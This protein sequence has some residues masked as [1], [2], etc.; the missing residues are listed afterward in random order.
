MAKAKGKFSKKTSGKI[1]TQQDFK[2][3]KKEFKKHLQ[4]GGKSTSIMLKNLPFSV[5][6]GDI[7]QHFKKFGVICNVNLP[8]KKG[9]KLTG[10]GFV[11]FN[12]VDAAESAMKQCS[13]EDFMGRKLRVEWAMPL[14]EVK[15]DMKKEKDNSARKGKSNN[16]RRNVN[17]ED[18]ED[19]NMA[20]D[21]D[22]NMA[23]EIEDE[24]KH[25]LNTNKPA[26]EEINSLSPIDNTPK[27]N[28]HIAKKGKIIVR[29]LS[30]KTTEEKL[31]DYFKEFGA[32]S[33]VKLLKKDDGKLVGCGFV[34]FEKKLS[35]QN[36]IQERNAK[37]FLGRPIVCDWAIPKDQYLKHMASEMNN[38]E[39]K[40]AL[41]DIKIKKEPC[42]DESDNEAH[43]KMDTE[44]DSDEKDQEWE[45]EEEEDDDDD[46]DDDDDMEEDEVDD[47][48]DDSENDEY[49]TNKRGIK[50]IKV[51]HEKESK[52]P[53][54]ISNDVTE[55]C[56]I[57]IKNIPFSASNDD[58]KKCMKQFGPLEYA[59]ICMDKLTEHSKGTGFVKFKKKEDAE[60]CLKTAEPI[61]INDQTIEVLSAIPRD[62]ITSMADKKKEKVVKDKR[63]LYLIKEGVIL[64]GSAAAKDVSVTDMEKRLKL[65]QWKTQM[66][67]NL[68]MFVSNTRL[69]IYNVPPTWSD[70]Q[71]R[72]L[73][74]EHAGPG[75]VIREARIMRDMRNIGA[76]GL[77]KSKEH[78]FVRFTEHKHALQALRNL[79]NNPNIFTKGKRP[80]V[81]FSIENKA[82]HKI[83]ERRLQKS[84]QA[85]AEK[86]SSNSQN[87]QQNS[88]HK[89]DHKTP[90]RVKEMGVETKP[91]S[92][93]ESKPGNKNMRTKFKLKTQAAVH[94]KNA[95]ESKRKWKLDKKAQ[96]HNTKHREPQPKK[97]GG[98]EYDSFSKL[99]DKYK[100]QLMSSDYH[101]HW[102][103]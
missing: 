80:I 87:Y 23:N 14:S 50:S 33:E 78:A 101:K 58:L 29:N 90:N 9:G 25:D 42:S 89:R 74:K 52:K 31:M 40:K 93:L 56:T 92:G 21:K 44:V 48:F 82:I 99:V 67:R 17:K 83:R 65:E 76:D 71:I 55:G 4:S 43:V 27:K 7:K 69:I 2:I 20:N 91:Y 10:N 22:E 49:P 13:G 28:P 66:L 46:D 63:H 64:A 68:N 34:Q 19:D 37:P 3:R 86:Q 98:E 5:K 73:F 61:L 45:E 16:I 59:L 75:A 15:A 88:K 54:I 53:K 84:R 47:E 62:D 102:Y 30:F 8:T 100:S 72:Q 77:G 79:N 94:Q 12:T 1:K 24:K 36:A 85:I 103:E 51:E 60:A 6:V 81:G 57:F 11:H 70:A 32:I 41:N 96:K 39:E 26:A 95:K 35:A 38:N 18:S 97:K